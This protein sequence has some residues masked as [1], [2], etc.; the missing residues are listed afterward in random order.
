MIP[1]M[2]GQG[3]DHLGEQ[4]HRWTGFV[5]EFAHHRPTARQIR[6]EQYAAIQKYLVTTC[7]ELAVNGNDADRQFFTNLENLA[8]PWV[9][10]QA[11]E[12]IAPDLLDDLLT[13][14]QRADE[15]LNGR[16]WPNRLR[17]RA[18]PLVFIGIFALALAS[19]L[20]IG[21]TG[22]LWQGFVDAFTRIRV[23]LLNAT[24][25]V[26][27]NLRIFLATVLLCLMAAYAT[28]RYKRG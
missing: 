17:R 11:L 21:S 16:R 25:Q 20:L 9:S 27:D 1:Q 28:W 5:S 8:K 6:G 12:Q 2:T 14:C 23:G 7:R 22:N 10:P 15:E 3:I 18:R 19:C 4:W 13:R 26:N 24:A